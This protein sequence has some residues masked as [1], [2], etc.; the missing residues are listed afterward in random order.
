MKVYLKKSYLA[1]L[2]QQD[3]APPH[4][5]HIFREL[6]DM[7]FPE[8]LIS[9]CGDTIRKLFTRPCDLPHE[10]KLRIFAPIEAVTPQMLEKNLEGN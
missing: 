9:S 1:T 8:R 2:F 7:H 3:G 6:L 4:W 5:A 10:L